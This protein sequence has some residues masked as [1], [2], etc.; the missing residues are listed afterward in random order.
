[1]F[2][3]YNIINTNGNF[4][5]PTKIVSIS[6]CFPCQSVSRT[7]CFSSYVDNRRGS[8]NTQLFFNTFYQMA[9]IVHRRTKRIDL[10]NNL[11]SIYLLKL[12]KK[13]PTFLLNI[14][15]LSVAIASSPLGFIKNNLDLCVIESNKILIQTIK[16]NQLLFF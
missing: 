4:F 2:P 10:F 6:D 8:K 15:A 1:L 9:Q 13:K 7:I 14:N 12:Y 16:R 5:Q 11:R 3:N